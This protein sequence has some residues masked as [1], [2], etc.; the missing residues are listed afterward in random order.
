[1]RHFSGH[2]RS[3]LIRK[4]MAHESQGGHENEEKMIQRGSGILLHVTSLPSPYGIGDMGPWSYRFVDFL[5]ESRQ[6]YWQ[7]LPLNP[8]DPA[9][10]NSPYHSMSAFAGNTLLISPE[11]LMQEG[12][13]SGETLSSLPEFPG[14][15]V[16]YPAVATSREGLFDEVWNRVRGQQSNPDFE[17]FCAEHA[18][19]LNDF[20]LFSALKHRFGYKRWTEWPIEFRDRHPEAL[21]TAEVELRE[22][23]EQERFLQYLFFRQWNA[24]KGYCNDKRIC[25]IGDIPIY[26]IHDSVDVWAHPDHFN[27][28]AEKNPLTVAGVP[29]DYFSETGQLWGNP[30]YRWDVLKE[31]GY[32]WWIRRI[33]HNLALFD[34]VRVDHFRG[35]VG[36]WEVPAT[37]KNAI[38]GQWVEAPGMDFF[39]SLTEKFPSLPIVAEDLGII[40]PDV[41]EVRDHFGFPGMKVMLFAFGED[42]PTNPYAPHNHIRNCVVY[43]GTHD[44][45]T[46]RAWFE[47]EI[48]PETKDR[49]ARYLGRKVTA[50][51][52]SRELVRL[53][54]MSVADCVIFPMQDLLGLGEEARMNR[55]AK[56]KGNWQWRLLPQH[57]SPVLTEELRALTEICGRGLG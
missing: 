6:R 2:R 54:M 35:F 24:L 8:T 3:A 55:P 5:S 9:H 32:E 50:E 7:I 48:P 46:T 42:L 14:D 20:S 56:S 45:N 11:F 53:A 29:P 51:N 44:N 31:K 47:K 36:Y 28:D 33:L 22:S 49:L 41:I 34:L 40:T 18:G 30:V 12:L 38:R 13:I 4:T 25:L 16:N 23:L 37:E 1:M 19:W 15:Q 10:G 39:D 57:L 43:T 21:K 27:L 17:A 26:V 52:I